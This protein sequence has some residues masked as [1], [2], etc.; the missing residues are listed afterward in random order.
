MDGDRAGAGVCQGDAVTQPVEAA[1]AGTVEG[2]VAVE[3]REGRGSEGAVLPDADGGCLLGCVPAGSAGGGER[4]G[5]AEP[6]TGVFF[7]LSVS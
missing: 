6:D 1:D 2:A 4:S 3:G 5:T 7:A